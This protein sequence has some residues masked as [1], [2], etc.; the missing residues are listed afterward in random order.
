MLLLICQIELI[1][2]IIFVNFEV[3]KL[4]LKCACHLISHSFPT[5]MCFPALCSSFTCL[6]DFMPHNP[7]F[8]IILSKNAVTDSPRQS[9]VWGNY[10]ICLWTTLKVWN[11]QDIQVNYQYFSKN[12]GSLAISLLATPWDFFLWTS[13]S[14]LL[15]ENCVRPIIKTKLFVSSVLHKRK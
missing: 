15:I 11:Y 2:I 8:R 13:Y 14:F 4:K 10:D 7:T 9:D 1:S 3:F 12:F 5:G 6:S